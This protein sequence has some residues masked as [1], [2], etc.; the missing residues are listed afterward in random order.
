MDYVVLE[1]ARFVVDDIFE[2]GSASS[3]TSDIDSRESCSSFCK[4]VGYVI[5]DNV[6]VAGYPMESDRTTT[7]KN[8][9]TEFFGRCDEVSVIRWPVRLEGL[10]RG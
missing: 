10:K 7:F 6:N 4:G 8:N 3:D 9:V 2:L 1:E 5:V